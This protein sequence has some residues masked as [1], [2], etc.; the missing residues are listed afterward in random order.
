MFLKLK[1]LLPQPADAGRYAIEL[2]RL[3]LENPYLPPSDCQS[4]PSTRR[5]PIAPL[6][7]LLAATLLAT[8]IFLVSG[9]FALNP[10][11]LGVTAAVFVFIGPM[12]RMA[13]QNQTLGGLLYIC[14]SV[15][16]CYVIIEF[17]KD[18]RATWIANWFFLP[19]CILAIPT[20]F[21]VR[22]MKAMHPASLVSRLWISV[23]AFLF[24]FP[25]WAAS[26]I[27]VGWQIGAWKH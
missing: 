12:A 27:Y 26:C 4:L 13:R 2:R 11:V 3:G 7:F 14:C 6:H 8:L 9:K 5:L 20:F 16:T 25:L 15:M 18:P 23:L 10:R 22:D 1:L 19:I 24:L 21:F 17:G